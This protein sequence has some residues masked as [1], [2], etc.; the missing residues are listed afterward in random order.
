MSDRC[1]SEAAFETATEH[2]LLSPGCIDLLKGRGS[3]LAFSGTDPTSFDH[4]G[5][6]RFP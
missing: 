6:L 1:H 2:D 5:H 3:A 4:A